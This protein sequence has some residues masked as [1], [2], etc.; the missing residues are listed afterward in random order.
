M[1]PEPADLC[2]SV[3]LD[4]TNACLWRE[5]QQ[6]PL[7]P[8][9]FAVL[10]CLLA[11]S[12]Q[13]VTKAALLDAVWPETTVTDVALMICIRELRRALGDDPKTPQFIETIHRRGYGSSAIF[14]SLL[15]HFVARGPHCAV[16]SRQ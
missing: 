8:K 10:R 3:R 11:H 16:L 12:G 5:A 9:T 15:R 6:I 13:L 2:A 4:L 14:P 7:R 1:P